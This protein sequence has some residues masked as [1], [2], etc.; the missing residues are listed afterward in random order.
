[1]TYEEAEKHLIFK[2]I[3]GSHAYGTARKDEQGNSLS[4]FDYRGVFIAPLKYGFQLF[5]TSQTSGDFRNNLKKS[6]SFLAESKIAEA[7]NQI[8]AALTEEGGDM[9]FGVSMVSA[10]KG[11]G[12]D[13]QYHELRKFL[14]LAAQNNPNILEFLYID[15][16]VLIETPIWSKIKANRHLFLSKNVRFTFGGYITSQ[17]K[18]MESYRY[19]AR[20]LCEVRFKEHFNHDLYMIEKKHAYDHKHAMHIVRLYRM[21]KEILKTGEV[22]VHRP[23]ANELLEIRNGEWSYEQ[24]MDYIKDTDSELATL[25]KN[26]TLPDRPNHAKISDLYMEICEEVYGIKIR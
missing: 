8:D 17:I 5:Q 2:F 21:V 16:N 13:A 6:L 15:K 4:D 14:K 1:M 9:T 3:G 25:Y 10:P 22:L 18:K 20:E 24:V 12:I 19:F 7:R 11:S 26:C 23:D